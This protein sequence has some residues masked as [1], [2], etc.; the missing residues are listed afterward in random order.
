M[1]S[2]QNH[3][4]YCRTKESRAVGAE[5]HRGTRKIQPQRVAARRQKELHCAMAFQELEWHAV[6]DVDFD[7]AEADILEI[8]NES[9]IPAL[10][11]IKPVWT[12]Y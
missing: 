6:D 2:K 4:S 8:V 12:S 5:Q 9:G 7:D 3:F 1:K 10:D 11:G